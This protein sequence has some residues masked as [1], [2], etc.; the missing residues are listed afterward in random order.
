MN[1]RDAE[2]SSPLEGMPTRTLTRVMGNSSRFLLSRR[3]AKA[4]ELGLGS[5]WISKPLLAGDIK[6]L[7]IGSAVVI[8]GWK[9]NLPLPAQSTI[10]LRTDL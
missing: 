9:L 2:E 3:A 5:G 6:R 10:S 4:C 8:A 1:E 7:Q